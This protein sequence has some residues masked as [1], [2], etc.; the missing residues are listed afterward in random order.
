[1]NA[2]LYQPL[3]ERETKYAV[4]VNNKY[5]SYPVYLHGIFELVKTESRHISI[6][7][8]KGLERLS[9]LYIHTFRQFLLH[10]LGLQEWH[11]KSTTRFANHIDIYQLQR[12]TSAFTAVQ[13]V[14]LVLNTIEKVE[15]VHDR[16]TGTLLE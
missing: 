1:M 4:P 14:S 15:F 2:E 13:L 7:P 6:N 5:C 3:Y 9:T 12:P 10:K 8:V 11:F 16:Y